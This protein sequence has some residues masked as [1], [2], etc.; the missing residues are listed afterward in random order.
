MLMAGSLRSSASSHLTYL[1]CQ[2]K[3]FTSLFRLS[4]AAGLLLLAAPS[5]AQPDTG[6]PQPGNTPAATGVPLDG[7][8]SLLAAAGVGLGLKKLRERRR[9]S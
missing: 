9:R 6:G 3:N 2:M 8:I 5:F 1:F 4:L 7:G